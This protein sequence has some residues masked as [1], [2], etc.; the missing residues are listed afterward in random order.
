MNASIASAITT[1]WLSSNRERSVMSAALLQTVLLALA[2]QRRNVDAQRFGGV[3]ERGGICHHAAD[4][5]TL[6]FFQAPCVAD[7]RTRAALRA[8]RNRQQIDV[9]LLFRAQDH[10]ALDDV[11]QFADVARPRIRLDRIE[12]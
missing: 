5:R 12:R 10:R 11:L 6:E 9:D 4:M 3:V 2:I 7:A 8:F 1:L